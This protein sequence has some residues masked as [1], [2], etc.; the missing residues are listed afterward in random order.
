[1]PTTNPHDFIELL[2]VFSIALTNGLLDK[3][4][5]VKWADRIITSDSEPEYFIIE[6]SLCGHKTLNDIVSLI[7]EFIGKNKPQVSGRVILGFLYKQYLA[8]KIT[9]RKVVSTINWIVWQAD[10]TDEEKSFMYGL[11]EDFECAEDGIYGTVEA[12]EKETICFLET[13]KD[14]QIDNYNDWKKI[15]ETIN[16]KIALLLETIRQEQAELI[17]M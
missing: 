3:S 2:E 11:D 16:N 1:M 10:L 15:D 12:V 8:R 17:K 4:E 7:N 9:L 6:L 5:V 14:F 13:Y